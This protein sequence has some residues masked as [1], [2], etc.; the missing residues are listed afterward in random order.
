MLYAQLDDWI[1][2]IH[3]IA[4]NHNGKEGSNN[5]SDDDNNCSGIA[6]INW[7]LL[8]DNWK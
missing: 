7:Q 6:R 5:N 3:S 2:A 4:N 8:I 1:T